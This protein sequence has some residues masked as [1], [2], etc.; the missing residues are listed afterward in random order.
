M[1][2]AMLELMRASGLF[3]ACRRAHRDKIL[4]LTYHRFSAQPVPGALTAAA[5]AEQLQYLRAHYSVVPLSAIQRHLSEGA[6][7]PRAAVAVTIDDGYRDAYEIAF[8][9]LRRFGVPATLFAATGFIDGGWLWTD[10]PRYVI[11]QSRAARLCIE[12]GGITLEVSL[13]GEATRRDAAARFNARLKRIPVGERQGRIAELARQAGVTVPE[14]PPPACAPATWAELREMASAGIDIGSHT[15][16]HPIL[17]LADEEMLARELRQSR[18]RLETMLD[19]GVTTFCYPN[20]DY[21]ARVRVEVARAGY[22]LAVTTKTGLNDR[23]VD[24][25]ELRRVHTDDDLVHFIQG[26]SGFDALKQR[27]RA[28]PS[29]AA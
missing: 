7:L 5:F 19:S 10:I 20:G 26:T 4:V 25:L 18:T 3:A 28:R 8:P 2:Q 14:G 6:P 16:T 27:V 17:P 23:S 11:D 29:A 24:V 15:V 21:D 13:G 1:K 9:L 12:V 22:R